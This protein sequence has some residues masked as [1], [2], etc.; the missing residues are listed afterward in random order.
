MPPQVSTVKTLYAAHKQLLVKHF[1]LSADG[2]VT[3]SE[4]Q[5]VLSLLGWRCGTNHIPAPLG[6]K[7]HVLTGCSDFLKVV[8]GNLH[9]PGTWTMNVL[10]AS[11]RAHI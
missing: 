8:L 7:G 3:Q 5:D 10:V 1:S 9:A 4:L 11:R 6:G 2:N